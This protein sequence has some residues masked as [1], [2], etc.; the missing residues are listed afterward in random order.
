MRILH[1]S[2]WHLGRTLHGVDLGSAHDLFLDHLVDVVEQ[3]EVDAVLVAGDVFDRAYPPVEAVQRLDDVLARLA[4]RTRVVLT[5]GNHDSAQRLGFGSRLWREQ[6][7]VRTQV[8]DA[9]TPVLLPDRDGHLGAR[10]CCLPYLEPDLVRDALGADVD[11]VWTPAARSHEGVVGAA[12]GRVAEAMAAH[13]ATLPSRVPTVVM[14][15]AFVAGGLA[16][17]SEREIKVGGVDV[18]AAGTL[19]REG[20]DYVALGHLHGPQELTATVPMRYSGSPLAF[21]FS[22][23]GH[24]KGMRLV[25]LGSEGVVREE[26]VDAPVHR[27][28]SE[29]RGS[30]DEITSEAHVAQRDHYVKVT[31]TDQVR[32]EHLTARVRDVFPHALVVAHEP[33]ERARVSG[34]AAERL[35]RDPS[36]VLADFVAQVRGVA[37]DPDELAVLTSAW[38]AARTEE[39]R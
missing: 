11:G 21:S 39:E 1:T 35:T 32:P 14:A 8:H 24:T 12:M 15:H 3:E 27:A 22:E 25:E 30:L 33:P 9:A 29:L 31:V 28:L 16:S 36:A 4:E 38:E 37:A 34:V 5:S 19:E 10:V 18:V 20:V 7:V 13:D 17:D 2:D 6:V 26:T 23:A